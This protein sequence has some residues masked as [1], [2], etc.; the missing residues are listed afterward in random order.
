MREY[1]EQNYWL[2][3][4]VCWFG[5]WGL[6]CTFNPLSQRFPW[7]ISLTNYAQ[8]AM[9]MGQVDLAIETLTPYVSLESNKSNSDYQIASE[10]LGMAYY[11]NLNYASAMFHFQQAGTV[12]IS[13]LQSAI[14][15]IVTC[16]E[17]GDYGQAVSVMRQ[18]FLQNQKVLN[19]KQQK[20]QLKSTLFR[21]LRQNYAPIVRK[22]YQ[23]EVVNLSKNKVAT[24]K[25]AATDWK[26][27]VAVLPI[28]ELELTP[29]RFPVKVLQYLL[30]ELL[31]NGPVKVI[32]I[33]VLD[34]VLEVNNLD[35]KEIFDIQAGVKLARQ[36]G[37]SIIVITEIRNSS[38]LSPSISEEYTLSFT[39][40]D[41][42]KGRVY[43]SPTLVGIGSDIGQKIMRLRSEILQMVRL[44]QKL[45]PTFNV[46]QSSFENL[47]YTAWA[48]YYLDT[49]INPNQSALPIS[50]S[51]IN[52]I[53][54][55]YPY[56]TVTLPVRIAQEIQNS[57]P[58]NISLERL[59]NLL[60]H[61]D[62]QQVITNV[63]T[64]QMTNLL[65]Q[66]LMFPYVRGNGRQR[67][68]GTDIP[69]S[70]VVR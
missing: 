63:L 15:Y 10:T 3:F 7:Q 21:R 29:T 23:Q 31:A 55:E 4:L 50:L 39:I 40:L 45:Q 38:A 60:E 18:I 13:K 47:F 9:D 20:D 28:I 65:N 37:F 64:I 2:F 66:H 58:K 54:I 49:E 43:E 41:L 56:P 6:G 46:L 36:F 12:A 24:P 70:I 14:P 42:E 48:N 59:Q 5:V 34:Q 30:A 35:R 26:N 19:L 53:A 25:N 1:K 27:T 61:Y 69:I 67:F 32:P 57:L 17:L 44:D 68:S 11:Q 16:V 33:A 8:Q 62:N 22:Y 52:Q 51:L